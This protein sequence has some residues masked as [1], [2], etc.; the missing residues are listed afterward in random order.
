MRST[1][2]CII[3]CAALLAAV[4]VGGSPSW[5]FAT[6]I[7]GT[8]PAFSVSPD[9]TCTSPEAAPQVAQ[10]ET[11]PMQAPKE[12]QSLDDLSAPADQ[13]YLREHPELARQI[14]I[15]A[16]AN[17]VIKRHPELKVKGVDSIVVRATE[18]SGEAVI[19]VVTKRKSD[20]A[21]VTRELPPEVEGFKVQ[22]EGPGVATWW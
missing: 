19:A 20:V 16:A 1:T 15:N 13:E 5:T 2:T 9:G 12:A 7:R 18:T 10:A 4:I 11:A 3:R 6:P 8:L 21:R 14:E 17:D 22:V